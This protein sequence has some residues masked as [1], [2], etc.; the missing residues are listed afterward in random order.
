[1][2]IVL[3]FPSGI[4]LSDIQYSRQ[5]T[6]ATQTWISDYLSYLNHFRSE[7]KLYHILSYNPNVDSLLQDGRVFCHSPQ[8]IKLNRSVKKTTIFSLRKTDHRMTTNWEVVVHKNRWTLSKKSIS[9][10]WFSW[11]FWQVLS[12]VYAVVQLGQDKTRWITGSSAAAMEGE[13]AWFKVSSCKMM[14]LVTHEEGGLLPHLV[15][16]VLFQAS[17]RLAGKWGIYEVILGGETATWA[18]RDCHVTLLTEAD[19][20]RDG[21]QNLH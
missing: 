12:S 15:C 11:D 18:R 19:T 9:L 6:T 7:N 1:M 20:S 13:L 21:R 14:I 17:N 16:T 5:E 8:T 2:W 3:F 4:F 10:W